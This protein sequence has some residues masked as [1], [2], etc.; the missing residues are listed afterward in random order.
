MSG[1]KGQKKFLPPTEFLLA[2]AE[3]RM[4]KQEACGH[5]ELYPGTSD[6]L[7]ECCFCGKTFDEDEWDELEWALEDEAS[8]IKDQ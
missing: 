2:V 4:E 3:R 5:T 1:K 6:N 7:M 8:M